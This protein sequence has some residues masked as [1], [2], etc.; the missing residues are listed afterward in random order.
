MKM[1]TRPTVQNLS[2]VAK[3]VLRRKVIAVQAYIKK[4][5]KSQMNNLPLHVKR[6]EKEKQ[7]KPKIIRRKKI[8]KIRT[9]INDVE[10]KKTKRSMKPGA[11]FLK[12]SKKPTKLIKL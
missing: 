5:G 10:T 12:R 3:A 11:D 4:Q 7:T 8:I 2:D 9:E 1:K 6:I